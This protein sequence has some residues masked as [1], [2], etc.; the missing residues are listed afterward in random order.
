MEPLKTAQQGRVLHGTAGASCSRQ[1]A[2]DPPHADARSRGYP[3]C[4]QDDLC[5]LLQVAPTSALH[6]CSSPWQT[7]PGSAS[8]LTAS[9]TDILGQDVVSN[10]AS[11]Y[12][13]PL[14]SSNLL[15]VIL[16][17][18]QPL[19]VCSCCLKAL[20]NVIAQ[21]TEPKRQQRQPYQLPLAAHIIAVSL[22]HSP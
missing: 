10:A 7:Q 8:T 22:H 2:H 1:L 5:Y 18:F 16:Q 12:K 11:C 4:C 21:Y 14:G 13:Q 20:D 17:P 6:C 9:S 15:I 3:H 19:H